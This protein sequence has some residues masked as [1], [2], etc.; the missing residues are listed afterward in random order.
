MDADPST[1][2]WIWLT[3]AVVLIAGEMAVPGTFILIPFGLSAALAMVLAFLDVHV[4]VQWL[5]FVGVGGGL[6]GLFWRMSRRSMREMEAPE[7]AGAD[8][9]LGVRGVV[10]EEIPDSPASSGSVRIGGETWRAVTDGDPI[11]EGTEVEVVAVRGTRVVVT[12]QEAE[13]GATP[14][15]DR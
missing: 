9:L 2:Q 10:T 7:G 4:A 5:V 14:T 11:G 13:S 3:A 1:W 15:A 12:P 8:R 6:F